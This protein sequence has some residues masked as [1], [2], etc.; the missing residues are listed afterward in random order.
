[1][2]CGLSQA[3]IDSATVKSLTDAGFKVQRNADEDT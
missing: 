1:M 3:A 2:V